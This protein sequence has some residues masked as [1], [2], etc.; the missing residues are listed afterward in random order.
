[1]PYIGNTVEFTT[2]GSNKA[3]KYIATSGQTVFSGA[4]ANTNPLDCTATQLLDVYLNGI[5]LI[6]GDDYTQAADE[7]TL[8]S[9][10]SLNDELIIRTDVTFQ[11][12]D[13]VLKADTKLPIIKRDTTTAR[14]SIS[15]GGYINITNRAGSDVSVDLVL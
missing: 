12:A 14:V 5:R 9:G 4:D 15:S 7:L 13:H 11:D 6:K 3:Y 8:L 2:Q 10:A 1:M